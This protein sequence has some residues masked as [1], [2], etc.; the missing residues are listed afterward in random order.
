MSQKQTQEWLRQ[1]YLKRKRSHPGYSLRDFAKFLNLP[2][3]RLSE[4]MS[5]KRRITAKLMEKICTAL[6]AGEKE[7]Q[8]LLE[9]ANQKKG[10]YKPLKKQLTEKQFS[11]IADW[12][13][14]AILSLLQTTDFQSD[15]SWI[16]KRLGI[17]TVQCQAAVDRLIDLGL[18]KYKDEDLIRSYGKVLTTTDVT[19]EALREAY[20]QTLTHAMKS[21]DTYSVEER[22]IGATTLVF[23]PG[24]LPEVKKEIRKHRRKLSELCEKHPGTEVYELTTIFVPLTK[25]RPKPK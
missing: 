10:E 2:P 7:R 8:A 5:G 14:F 21:L 19:S 18:L 9:A 11:V 3:G 4:L 24:R 20:R 17:S 6:D 13:H 23:D 16:A 25:L 1:Q 22:E 12:Y 15:V